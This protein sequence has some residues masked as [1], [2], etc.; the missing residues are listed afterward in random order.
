M[1]AKSKLELVLE[2]KNK[3]FNTKLKQSKNAYINANKKMRQSVDKLKM[4]H[5]MAFRSMSSEIP[6]LGRAVDLL[7]NRYVLMG[8]AVVGIGATLWAA[9]NKAAAFNHEF[10]QIKNLNLDKSRSELQAYKNDIRDTAFTLGTDLNKTATAFYDVQS[11]TGLFG[12]EAQ[13][14][15]TSVGKFSIA[16]GADLNDSINATT[17]AMKA[18]NLGVNEIDAYLESNAKTVQVGIT[19]FKELAE[20]QTEYA[21]A[22]SGAGQSVDTANK[23]FAAF[24]SIAKDSQTAATMTKTAFQGLTQKSTIEGLKSIGIKMYDA[25][26]NM[27]DLGDVMK[28][29]SAKFKNMSPKQIDEL[30]NKIGGPEGLRNLFVKLKT[31]SEDFFNTLEAFDS[32]KFNLDKALKN[33]QGDVTVLTGIVKNRFGVVMERLGQAVLPIFAKGLNFINN[34]LVKGTAYYKENADTI[35]LIATMA[36]YAVTALAGFKIINWIINMVKMWRAAQISLNVVLFANPIGIIIGAIAALIGAIVYVV[37]HVRGWGAQW[38]SI[39]TGMKLQ[40]EAFKE[41]LV[42][43]WE[44]IK[45]AFSSMGNKIVESWM[46]VKNKLGLI[47]DEQYAKE[48]KR[49]NDELKAHREHVKKKAELAA[50]KSLKANES[51]QWKLEWKSDKAEKLSKSKKAKGKDTNTNNTSLTTDTN[52][53]IGDTPTNDNTT[54]QVTNVVG[55]AKQPRNIT[56]NI[57]SFIKG[58][59]FTKGGERGPLTPEELEQVLKE[60]FGRI[61]RN[62]ELMG[63]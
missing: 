33:A 47:S 20:V 41:G 37:K 17:K 60:M 18:F 9:K 55:S 59:V 8:A 24:T 45:L 31:G 19:T 49:L 53:P 39:V 46:W 50:Q 43:V 63:G 42:V 13:S 2:L 35:N 38:D 51:L 21:G 6:M 36:G 32:S 10:L 29:V 62:V 12:K 5:A 30:I 54:S 25:K 44:R 28:E 58:D 61:V 15:V 34:L 48:K 52:T 11:A 57:D 27:R 22:A 1:A 4:K 14:V 23:I 3:L 7:T 56:I 40:M 16:T 26:D